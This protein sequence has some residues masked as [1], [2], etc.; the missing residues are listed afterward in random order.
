MLYKQKQ[1]YLC[2]LHMF[3]FFKFLVLGLETLH[4]A[5]FGNIGGLPNGQACIGY[6]YSRNSAPRTKQLTHNGAQLFC[7]GVSYSSSNRTCC[8]KTS[9]ALLGL[10]FFLF[11]AA[12]WQLTS[13]THGRKQHGSH[14][15]GSWGSV[16]LPKIERLNSIAA[17]RDENRLATAMAAV[18]LYAGRIVPQ[19]RICC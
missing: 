2:W 18:K 9:A 5:G 14:V 7:R 6:I 16:E 13:S 11:L 12:R 3:C 15:L 1:L 10:W 19:L 8:M 4:G 17:S